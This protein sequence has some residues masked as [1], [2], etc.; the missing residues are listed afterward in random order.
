MFVV[1]EVETFLAIAR[2]GSLAEAAQAVHASQSTVSYRLDNLENRLG[3]TLV[4]RARGR[5][6]AAL[7][8]AG[9]HYRELAERWERLVSEAARLRGDEHATLAIG[10]VDAISIHLFDPL[11]SELLRRLPQ[12]R[13]TVETGLGGELS[14]RVVSSHLDVAFVFYEPVHADL[15][16]RLLAEYPMLAMH[17]GPPTRPLP[18]ADVTSGNEIYLPWGPRFDLWRERHMLGEPTHTVAK[19]HSLPPIL[20]APSAWAMVPEF[21]VDEVVSKTGCRAAPLVDGPPRQGVYW[22]ERKQHRAANTAAL[23]TL[24]QVLQMVFAPAS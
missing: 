10:S 17:H 21:M 1:E 16:V 14:D 2:S 3:R 12:L 24:A 7:T 15:R 5:K 18:L 9:L 8:P 22:V 6:G 13:L 19:A 11:I 4:M 23:Q 20:R